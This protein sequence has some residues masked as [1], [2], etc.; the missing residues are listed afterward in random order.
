M[1]CIVCVRW[2]LLLL[3]LR[4]PIGR[5]CINWL[6]CVPSFSACMTG[7]SATG[8]PIDEHISRYNG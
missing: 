1:A 7:Q 2:L 8:F 3:L 4:A 6:S 5:C